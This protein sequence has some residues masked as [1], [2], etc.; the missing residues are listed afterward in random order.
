MD[1]DYK[2]YYP[3]GSLCSKVLGFTGSDN[4]GIVGLEVAYDSYLQGENG[5]IL[6]ITDAFGVEVAGAGEKRIKP[7]AG[8]NLVTGIDMNIQTYATQLAY[9]VMEKKQAESVSIIVMNPQNGE[10]M[11][12]TNVPEFD[13][14]NPFTLTDETIAAQ[15]IEEVSL[16]DEKKRQDALNQMW[17]NGCIN[18]T[19]EPGSIFK[20]VIAAIGL[21]TDAVTI[22]DQFS[23]PGF[24]VVDD[25]RIRCHKKGGHG[26]ETFLQGTMNSCKPVFVS[27][28]LLIG[29]SVFYDYMDKMGILGKTGIDL[30]G[31]AATIMHQEKNIGNVE[32]AT[33]SF[34]QSFQITAVQMAATASA[35]VNGGIRVIPHVGVKI[36][37]DENNLIQELS[38]EA[39]KRILSEETSEE[40]QYILEQV[41][42]NGTGKNGYVEGYSV[43]GKT[44]TSET[45]PRGHG[46]YIASFMGFSPA[47]N[48]Q[49]LAIA[50][51]NNPKGTYYGGQVAAPV[52]RQLFENILPYLE[53]IDYN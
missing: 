6:T 38:Y 45:L 17:R 48:P 21:E 27:V 36:V 46:K 18:D 7:E 40:M 11:A 44:A 32:L 25:R 13:L 41:V 14:N 43:G 49:V 30:P 35:I 5:T 23:C 3:Y 10:I 26:S 31:E 39:D 33:V 22:E 24:I 47:D 1:E 29:V 12:M 42:A 4:Q 37:D 8:Y 20:V 19:Y 50:I 9:Q 28:G 15:Q 51:I 53:S 34:G 2:R 52:I 16:L